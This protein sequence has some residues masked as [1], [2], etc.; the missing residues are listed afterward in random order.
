LQLDSV[1]YPG[2]KKVNYSVF[3]KTG[4]IASKNS[5]RCSKNLPF[6]LRG[7][8]TKV[9]RLFVLLRNSPTTLLQ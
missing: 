5:N 3:F 4:S 7:R 1:L 9:G 6:G 2:I 8:F